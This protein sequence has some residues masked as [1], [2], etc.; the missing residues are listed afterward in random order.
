MQIATQ[1]ELQPISL[2]A[3][4]LG[5][6]RISLFLS[7]AEGA[8]DLRRLR[9]LGI[10]TVV[11]CAVN[12]DINYVQD[13]LLPAEPGK[14]AAGHGAIRSYKIGLIDGE[15]NPEKMMLAGYYILEGALAQQL[16][17]KP[18]YPMRERGN[19]LVH[20]RGGRSRSVALA[21][22]FLHRRDPET[23]PTLEAAVE[24]VRTQRGLREEE[25]FETPKPMLLDAA[26]RALDAIAILESRGH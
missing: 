10:T 20:C 3:E 1:H 24:H 16:P 12:L 18:S 13:P 6:E 7:G 23:Y 8:R 14:C 11:N 21:A 22:L 25:R 26:R 15:G 4:G 9:E 17:D 19:V 5:E 2:I